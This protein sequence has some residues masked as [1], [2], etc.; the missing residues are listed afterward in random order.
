MA[1][2]VLFTKY[3]VY[4]VV[5]LRKNQ[6]KDA[7]QNLPDDQASDQELLQKL[8]ADF[9]LDVPVLK[10]DEMTY[11]E[12][13]VKIDARR[14][15]NRL[16]RPGA[17][18]VMEDATELTFHIPFDGDPE[19]FD[20]HPAASNS[21]LVEG[22]IV[23]RELL[24]HLKVADGNYD[25][26]A[27]VGR[28]LQQVTWALNQ[29]KSKD[30]Y[31][32]QELG[33]ALANEIAKR[34]RSI[35]SRF[36]VT[37]NL[38]I[39]RRQT[40]PETKPVQEIER[41]EMTTSKPMETDQK[42]DVLISHA[43]EDKPYV[44]PLVAKLEEA[45]ISVWYDRL[46]LE[47][48]DDLRSKIDNGLANC[49][50]GIVVL[51]KAF[52]GKKKW[53]E[54]ELNGLFAREQAGQ[55]L[56]LPIWHGITRDDLLQYSPAFADR[57][58]KISGTDSFED[59]V[60]SFRA[61]LGR[62]QNS[63]PVN[64]PLSSGGSLIPSPENVASF[65][66]VEPK[67]GHARFRDA[68]QPLGLFWNQLPHSEGSECEV[69]LAEGAAL[70]LRLSP[71]YAISREWNHLELLKSGRGPNV[72]LLPLLWQSMQYLRAEDGIGAYATI[73]N[74][75][76]ENQTNSVAF[77]FNTG[78]LWAVD[79]TVLQLANNRRIDFL[80][81]ARVLIQ[82]LNRYGQFL[83]CL[84]IASPFQ[85]TAG[86]EGVKGWK[87]Q[88]PDTVAE[89][90]LSDVIEASGTYDVGQNPAETLRPFFNRMFQKCSMQLPATIDHAIRTHQRF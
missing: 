53:T 6:L 80:S 69:Y 8:K 46:V 13:K 76:N 63:P 64:S 73:N 85:W 54:H 45:G 19:V 26:Q 88:A 24:L 25:I 34:K 31:F 87:L 22:E 74:M 11:D 18:P 16:I 82:N 38:N 40:P 27:H 60:H 83:Q 3:D 33:A 30:A 65:V 79:T 17:G 50:Y 5:E 72:A 39:P 61:L 43:S 15:P 58:A 1:P 36:S 77:A 48:G 49:R 29:I 23:G 89:T 71:R 14:L 4:N 75:A 7:Y 35:E 57:L 51:S 62:Q 9:M 41:K 55:K 78:E 32:T 44:E 28:E 90:C 12:D 84:G 67:K 37:S 52:L 59:I 68:G 81:V 66:R 86:I 70:W 21:R 56:I 10:P 20:I 42:K 2:K 47:W